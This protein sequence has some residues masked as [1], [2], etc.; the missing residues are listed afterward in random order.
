MTTDTRTAVTVESSF[1]SQTLSVAPYAGLLTQLRFNYAFTG[2]DYYPQ[3]YSYVGWNIEDILATNVQQQG[4][5]IIDATNFSFT[6]VQAG[7]YLLQAQ[8]VIF[9]QLSA[10]EFHRPRCH[11]GEFSFVASHAT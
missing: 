4:G 6:A 8:P 10:F 11:G 1:T 5:T 7:T 9:K 2:G 3:S